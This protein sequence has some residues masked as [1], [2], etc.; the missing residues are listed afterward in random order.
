MHDLHIQRGRASLRPM[1][2]DWIEDLLAVLDTGS[3]SRAAEQRYVTQ[4]AFTRR[5]R[6]IEDRIGVPLFDRARK[7]VTLRAGL[8]A[9]EPELRDLAARM[10]RLRHDLKAAVEGGGRDVTFVCQHAVTT[11]LSPWIVRQVAAAQDSTVRVRSGNRDHCLML[12]LS[13]EADFAVTYVWPDDPR[14]LLPQGFEARE[15]G[16]DALVPVAAPGVARPGDGRLPAITYPADVFLGR[17]MAHCILPALPEGVS[18]VPRAETAL[19]LAACEYAMD[20]IG[21]A[22]LPSSLVRK[23]LAEGRLERVPDLPDQALAVALL[24]LG[25]S[26]SRAA[27]IWETLARAPDVPGLS[28]GED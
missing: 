27:S 11:T 2:P 9:M 5:I 28:A 20:G 4:S 13:G 1:Q 3:L 18:L 16:W 22:W 6:A 10:R 19:T 14:P 25:G 8:R 23:P 26:D 12:L 24:R 7:P 21:V 15:L 17:V